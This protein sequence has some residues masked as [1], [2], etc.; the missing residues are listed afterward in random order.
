[1]ALALK[2]SRSHASK[3]ET[4]AISPTFDTLLA[5][6]NLLEMRPDVFMREVQ[7]EEK[8]GRT[9]SRHGLL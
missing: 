6:M 9:L 8:K 5:I 1:M 2:M 4:G 3:L 7:K